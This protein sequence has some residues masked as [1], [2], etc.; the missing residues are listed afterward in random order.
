MLRGIYYISGIF[1]FVVDLQFFISTA[2]LTRPLR[3]YRLKTLRW[4]WSPPVL[5]ILG[6]YML[7]VYNTEKL[8]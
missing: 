2:L 1:I 3:Q 4:A 7:Q 6:I 5:P 8:N